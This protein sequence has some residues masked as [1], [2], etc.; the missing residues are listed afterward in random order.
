MAKKETNTKLEI[1]ICDIKGIDSINIESLI[2]VIRGQQVM[3]DSDLAMLYGVETRTLNQAVK[4]NI[5]RFPEDFMF[6]LTQDEA[7]HSRSQFVTLNDDDALRSQIATSN[8]KDNPL[9]SQFVTSKSKRGQN[10]KYLP[11]AFTRNGIAML[12]SVLRSD[13]AVEVNIRIMRAFTMIPQLVNHNTQIIERIFNIEQHQ[14]ET[15]KT[16]KVILDRIENVNP[17]LLPEQVFPTGCVWDAWTYISDLVRS[18]QQ[19]IVLI[20]NYVDDRVL[21]MFTKRADGVSATIHTRHNEQF[22]TDLKKHNAQYP[23]IK[24]IQLPHRNHDRFLIIDDKVY[25]LGASLKD[26][27]TGLCAVTEMSITPEVI[28]GLLK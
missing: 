8:K 22:L 21:S 23:E 4:R 13:T 16:I 3:L 7:S 1:T 19:R 28:L 9:R 15:D 25:L 17:K 12:S 11:Y 5:K 20:D 2:R 26:M 18:A 14:Q 24:F 10:L 27:G 6:Q